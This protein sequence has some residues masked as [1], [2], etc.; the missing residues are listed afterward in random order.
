MALVVEADNVDEASDSIDDIL[1][2]E[3]WI[4]DYDIKTVRKLPLVR[5]DAP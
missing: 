4:K 3:Q 1:M 5:E 2:N